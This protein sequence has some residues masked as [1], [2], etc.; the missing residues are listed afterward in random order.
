MIRGIDINNKSYEQLCKEA[1]ESIPIYSKDWTNY[2][3]SDPGIT[4]LENFSAFMALQQSEIN[5]ISDQVKR[6]LLALT[7]YNAQKGNAA[8]AFV[9]LEKG[10]NPLYSAGTK[11][12]AQDICFAFE[13]SADQDAV[14]RNMEIIDIRSEQCGDDRAGQLLEKQ[15]LKRG[16]PLLGE[17]PVCGTSVYFYLKDIPDAGQRTAIYFETAGQYKRNHI[18]G[19]YQNPFAKIKWEIQVREGY[20][21]LKTE[22]STYCFL[23]SGY[24]VF[25]LDE[26]IYQDITKDR[27]EDAYVIRA[28]T[29]WADYDMPPSITRV[30][31]LLTE[32]VQKDTR[33]EIMI[34]TP[35]GNNDIYV[36][37]ELLK[38][39]CLELY[40]EEQ[41]GKYHRYYD[42]NALHSKDGRNDFYA[43]RIK[44]DT[45][46]LMLRKDILHRILVVCRDEAQ[47]SY[48]KLGVLYGYDGQIM[49]LPEMDCG[50]VYSQ[51]FTVLV[52]E[53]TCT[54]DKICHIVKPEN[55]TPGEVCYSVNE[56][57]NLLQIH[58]CGRYEGAQLRLGTFAVYRGSGGNIRAGT[59]L[60][61]K[62]GN[63]QTHFTNCTETTD[64]CY[65]ESLEQVRSRFAADVEFG[66][67]MVTKE[68][69]ERLVKKIP[70][71]AVH[72]IGVCSV[73]EKNEVHIVVK[74]NSSLPFPGLSA[75]YRR[76]IEKYLEK[77]RMLTTRIVIKQPVYVAVNVTAV[78]CFKKYFGNCNKQIEQTLEDMLDGIRSDTPFGSRVI[79]HELY[80]CLQ[81]MDCVEEVRGLTV[82]PESSRYVK[83]SG[84]DICMCANALYYPGTI[85]VESISSTA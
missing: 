36:R 32:A 56:S 30:S 23:Q 70:G 10:D 35:K 4:V 2:N 47:M 25:T 8:K 41:D 29:E 49:H 15:G 59:A 31:G 37:N 64:G 71:L 17:K 16:V 82:Y 14:I 1:V 73:P 20:V 42:I 66:A 6:R 74:P 27:Q 48:R 44:D 54:G 84:L 75:A 52:V 9:K 80:E 26:E 43:E 62:T 57:E 68:D 61:C 58:D 18:E 76:E 65:E 12:Y 11:L 7:G 22:D 28:V 40:V 77:Y 83:K 39:G 50:R 67:A 3:V 55:Y 24:V 46:K 60:T 72:K 34:L 13:R 19:A 78:L 51:D 21:P 69:C 53:K 5:E 85:R 33:S 81:N 79:F 38:N 45:V 63:I